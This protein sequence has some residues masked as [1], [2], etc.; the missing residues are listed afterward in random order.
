M[1]YEKT[2]D[3]FIDKKFNEFLDEKVKEVETDDEATQLDEPEE[4][5]TVHKKE[6]SENNVSYN[7]ASEVKNRNCDLAIDPQCQGR[8]KRGKSCGFCRRR[9][10]EIK[11]GQ[12]SSIPAGFSFIDENRLRV[13]KTHIRIC[14]GHVIRKDIGKNFGKARKIKYKNMVLIIYFGSD[15]ERVFKDIGDCIKLIDTDNVFLCLKKGAKLEIHPDS[16]ITG[17]NN[18]NGV[19]VNENSINYNSISERKSNGPPSS[20]TSSSVMDSRRKKRKTTPT[21]NEELNKPTRSAEEQIIWGLQRQIDQLKEE[22]VT[23]N[24]IIIEKN[25]I[26]RKLER[27]NKSKRS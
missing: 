22:I 5:T 26:I 25:K 2:T 7:E 3:E 16:I 11:N 12:R 14:L 1:E 20:S 10:K 23:N 19:G 18:N 15:C 17:P 21:E 4:N 24:N 8:V 13:P 27:K 9:W 6:N